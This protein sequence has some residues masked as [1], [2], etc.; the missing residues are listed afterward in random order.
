MGGGT[1]HINELLAQLH[2]SIC[3]GEAEGHGVPK[4][5]S[6]AV[7]ITLDQG[8]LHRPCYN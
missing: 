2:S 5:S 7:R 6:H 8:L 1:M 4:I 3:M